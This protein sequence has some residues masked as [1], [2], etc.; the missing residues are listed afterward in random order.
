MEFEP[1]NLLWLR[2][3]H[4]IV[5]LLDGVDTGNSDTNAKCYKCVAD[6]DSGVRQVTRDL[7]VTWCVYTRS[8]TWRSLRSTTGYELRS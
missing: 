2:S 1:P 4:Y 5:S 3:S 7:V 6:D 8:V